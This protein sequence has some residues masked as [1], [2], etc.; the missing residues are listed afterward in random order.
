MMIGIDVGGTFTDLVMAHPS[1]GLRFVKTLS[2]PDDPSVGVLDALE[3]LAHEMGTTV[4]TI[5]PTIRLFIH[6]TTVATNILVQRRG[7]KLGLIA[8]TGFRDLLELGNGSR[9]NRYALRRAAPEPIIARPLRLEVEERIG[10]DGEPRTP[11]NESQVGEAIET[12]RAA[13]VESVVVCFLHAHKNARHE[14]AVR[15]AIQ[16]TNWRPFISLSHEVLNREGEFDRLTT[17]SVN[18]YVGPGLQSYLDRLFRH[19]TQRGIN[20]PVM[21]MQSS[22]GV[23][24]IED[25]GRHA[26][27][28]ITSGPA[29]GAKAGAV[30]ARA[31]GLSHLVTSDMGGTTTDISIVHDGAPLER[32]HA[33][34]ADM[35]IT[36]SAIEVN[37]LG[38]GGGSIAWIDRSGI[39]DIGPQS[40]GAV[41]GPACF[42]RGGDR[43]T[44]TDANLALGLIGSKTFLDGRMPLDLG[45]ARAALEADVASLLG[46]SVDEAAWT[47][48]VLATSRLTEGI[49]LATVKRGLDPRHFALMSFGGAGGL[50]AN[51]IARALQIPMVIIPQMAAAFS[52]LGFLAADIRRDLQRTIA[53]PIGSLPPQELDQIFADL[54]AEGRAT[55][56]GIRAA[57]AG[58]AAEIW[59]RRFADCCYERQVHTVSIPVEPGDTPEMVEQRFVATYRTL[60]QHAPSGELGIIERCRVSVYGSLPKLDLPMHEVDPQ[61]DSA[62]ACVGARPVFL[63]HPCDVPVYAFDRLRCGMTISG[64]AIIDSAATTVLVL[65]DSVAS[66]D[67]TGS[68]RITNGLPGIP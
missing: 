34:F 44:L 23:L 9:G 46:I 63:G 39:L 67:Q 62:T 48:H 47:V 50:H 25:A 65:E 26:I 52:A 27:G 43:A 3:V 56:P 57:Q 16:A 2:T 8:T 30:F 29:G 35:R 22:G 51:A 37:P 6:G 32:D 11:L 12:L 40:A 1:H 21:V 45:K 14:T 13:G 7:A 19:L 10:F 5:L 66:I 53:Q 49:R 55:L 18:A 60:Y 24:P 61:A 64:P 38:I 41:P 33:D 15:A 58:P 68:L 42:N 17:A 54:E 36:A 28:A 20:V 59:T 31:L 4:E